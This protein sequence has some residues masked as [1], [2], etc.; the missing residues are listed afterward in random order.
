MRIVVVD[1]PTFV[2]I[3]NKVHPSVRLSLGTGC[4]HFYDPANNM[5]V[6]VDEET[7]V[8][9][10]PEF[11]GEVNVAKFYSQAADPEYKVLP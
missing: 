10:L 1:R 8:R 9:E 5:L 11:D 3:W 6:V 2:N 7:T 4:S